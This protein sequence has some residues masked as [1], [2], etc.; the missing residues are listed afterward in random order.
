MKF[1]TLTTANRIWPLIRFTA[2]PCPPAIGLQPRPSHGLN[3]RHRH[4]LKFWL[5][6]LSLLC[7]QCAAQAGDSVI[8]MIA[9]QN[10]PASEIQPLLAPMLEADEA[11]SGDGFNLFI[12]SS[13]H[14]L[15]ALRGLIGQLDTRLRNLIISV[16]QNSHQS[17]A[18]LNAEA[19]IRVSPRSIRMQG[20]AGDTRNLEQ[21]TNTQ[22]LRTLEGQAAHI[23]AGNVRPV[24][25]FNL[26]GNAYGYTGIAGNTQMQE[27]STGFAVV[28]RLAGNNEVVVDIEPWSGRFTHNGGVETR[29]LRTS[30]RA[31]L[32]EWLEIGG[33]HEQ[34]QTDRQRYNGLNYSTRNRNQSIL[35]KID[36]AD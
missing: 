10:R 23:Q 9:L 29:N 20:M 22:Q 1:N 27:A 32:G 28:P 11:V 5:T 18:Q 30:L 19:A 35:I 3:P 34:Q 16:M 15:Q 36:L 33:I 2:A 21:Q 26:Y 31:R 25:S 13:P 6:G 17:A 4:R 12:K 7:L 8:E 14:R 24:E